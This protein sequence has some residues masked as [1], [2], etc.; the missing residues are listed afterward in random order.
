MA[1]S[2]S[3]DSKKA[4]TK[5]EKVEK[6]DNKDKHSKHYGKIQKS[7]DPNIRGTKKDK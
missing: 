1:T 7:I 4:N 5:T 6:E 3:D 2:N